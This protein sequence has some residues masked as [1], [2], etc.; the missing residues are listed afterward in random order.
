MMD[1]SLLL[2]A[3][4][5]GYAGFAC[6]ALA[7]PDYWHRVGGSEDHPAGGARRLR[8]AGAAL[9]GAASL[10]CVWRD[11]PGFGLLLWGL[12]MPASA[13]AVAFTLT[14]RPHWLG[15]VIRSRGGSKGASVVVERVLA[16]E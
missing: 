16:G 7:M 8:L 15:A 11:G 1:V 5:A 3:A 9:L 12:M 13:L 10:A 6:L 4:L 14:W 2:L